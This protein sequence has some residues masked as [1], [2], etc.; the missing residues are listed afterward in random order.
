MTSTRI[1]HALLGVGLFALAAIVSVPL[2]YQADDLLRTAADPA[3]IADRKLDAVFDA[4]A[5]R[6]EI[7]AAL[8]AN[9]PDLAQSFLDLAVERGVVV[10]AELAGKVTAAV[11]YANSVAG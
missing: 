8:A 6:R 3:A 11:D 1:F 9:D 10:P 2:A 4:A 5:A 7:E